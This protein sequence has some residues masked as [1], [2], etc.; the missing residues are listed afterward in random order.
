MRNS[1]V[2]LVTVVNS[3]II[4]KDKSSTFHQTGNILE[5]FVN[6]RF[7][8]RGLQEAKKAQKWHFSRFLA[9]FKIPFSSLQHP[10]HD[11]I[12]KKIFLQ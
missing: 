9:N 4:R 1:F 11:V 8:I 7:M 6:S 5:L 10:I 12:F 2:I 3:Q